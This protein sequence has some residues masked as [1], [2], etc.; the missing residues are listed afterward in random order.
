VDT[1]TL[2]DTELSRL[3]AETKRLTAEAQRLVAEASRLRDE[4][5][6]VRVARDVVTRL[7]TLHQAE[8][9]P[10]PPPSTWAPSPDLDRAMGLDPKAQPRPTPGSPA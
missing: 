3:D 7:I 4:A 5:A 8:G 9:I 2:L 6:E 1:L 10:P